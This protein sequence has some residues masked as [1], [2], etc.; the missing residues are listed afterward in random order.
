ML[1][2]ARDPN[3]LIHSRLDQARYSIPYGDTY[4]LSTKRFLGKSAT[5]IFET[6]T[7]GVSGKQEALDPAVRAE[8]V[9]MVTGP[10]RPGAYVEVGFGFRPLAGRSTRQFTA[11]SPYIGVE[12]GRSD[13]EGVGTNS[14]M[15][16]GRHGMYRGEIARIAQRLH[17]SQPH[18]HL[19]VAD[20]NHL[21][22]AD[23]S[24]QEVFA[25]NV[26]L[27]P[28]MTDEGIVEFVTD[29]RRVLR[30]GALLVIG[31][32]TEG[33]GG[34][35]ISR[36]DTASNVRKSY[37]ALGIVL[38]ELG[39]T[40]RILVSSDTEEGRKI[41]ETLGWIEGDEQANYVIAR[42]SEDPSERQPGRL[43]RFARKLIGRF[44]LQN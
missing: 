4:G 5:E 34:G 24:A 31:E 35:D 30:P 9:G 22:L 39:F 3:W 8:L 2:M 32:S 11:E 38:D 7:R 16:F 28:G 26:V 1:G 27:A 14:A 29:S 25:G 37:G 21:P 41:S 36:T 17:E 19:L 15:G 20:G 23:A 18:A 6:V 13:Y 33:P 44:A 40:D 42:R 12:G 10:L 43:R